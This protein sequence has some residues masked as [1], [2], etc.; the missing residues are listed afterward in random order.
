MKSILFG[1]FFFLFLIPLSG[2]DSTYKYSLG[3]T[4]TSFLEVHPTTW[5]NFEFFTS[6]NHMQSF[7]FHLGRV[8]SHYWR[9]GNV[10][11][12]KPNL[13]FQIE[14]KS[15]K[16]KNNFS[17]YAGAAIDFKYVNYTQIKN[18]ALSYH[19]WD[20]LSDYV[21]DMHRESQ[22]LQ[23]AI[24]GIKGV[25]KIY[26]RQIT[27]DFFFHYGAGFNSFNLTKGI[28]EITQYD[29]CPTCLTF[30]ENTFRDKPIQLTIKLDAGMR[31]AYRF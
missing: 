1:L 5:V 18:I 17:T 22:Q 24:Q 16:H 14:T 26:K 19:P 11:R 29:Y 12:K 21:F 4:A 3:T 30:I 25:R 27:L 20:G 7:S 9:E 15:F 8:I 23:V 2:Q 6:K 28:E 13:Q 10:D 31:I